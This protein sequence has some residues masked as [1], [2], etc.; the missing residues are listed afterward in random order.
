[1]SSSAGIEKAVAHRYTAQVSSTSHKPNAAE[2]AVEPNNEYMSR[3]D[4]SQRTVAQPRSVDQVHI[5]H[6][7]RCALADLEVQVVDECGTIV[8][9][10]VCNRLDVLIVKQRA[11]TAELLLLAA[12]PDD[13]EPTRLDGNRHRLDILFSVIVDER[14]LHTSP[15]EVEAAVVLT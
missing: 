15:M 3:V 5:Q 12:T 1:M 14:A 7:L 10:A 11:L 8:T 9:Q 2:M 13:G 6:V 4:R